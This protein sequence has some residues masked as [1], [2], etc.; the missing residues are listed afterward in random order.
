MPKLNQCYNY[1]EVELSV[2]EINLKEFCDRLKNHLLKTYEFADVCIKTD[3]EKSEQ[4]GFG[5]RN[6]LV[7]TGG[8]AF[9][10]NPKYRNVGFDI[11]EV[12]KNLNA[13]NLSVLGSCCAHPTQINGH[14]GEVVYITKNGNNNSLVGSKMGNTNTCSK[15]ETSITGGLGNFHLTEGLPNEPV[16]YLNVSSRMVGSI[17]QS[18]PQ[19]IRS[20]LASN[21]SYLNL[22]MGG[23]FQITKGTIKGHIQP[24]YVDCPE[25]YYDSFNDCANKPFL[26]FFETFATPSNP[27]ICLT[28]FWNITCETAS[29]KKIN[30]RSNSEHTHFFNKDNTICGHYHGDLL[31]KNGVN[32]ECYL[33][34]CDK[35]VKMRDSKIEHLSTRTRHEKLVMIVGAGAMGCLFGGILAE[36]GCHVHLVDPWKEH[37]DKINKFG[38]KLTG[39]GGDRT[40]KNLVAVT[41][42][43]ELS[44]TPDIVIVQCKSM[45]TKD[46]VKSI[47]NLVD[48]KTKFVS[49]QNG[50]GN[51]DEIAEILGSS[52]N[53]FGGQTLQGANIVKPGEV[54]IHT[55]LPSYIGSWKNKQNYLDAQIIANFF[56]RHGLPTYYDCDIEKRIWMKVIYNCVV[57]PYSA[58]TR[59]THRQVYSTPDA[60]ENANLIINEAVNVAF[61]EGIL[62]TDQEA[63]ECLQKVID[64]KQENKSSMCYDIEANRHSEINYING[65]IVKLAEKHDV[66]VP[67][68]KTMEFLIKSIEY[69]FKND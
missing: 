14:C 15:Y 61:K 2:K 1:D 62:I 46:A 50:L 20:F 54:N 52:D 43:D 6:I 31:D 58:L 65:R 18:L 22:G 49:F 51:E 9:C 4:Y 53:V 24:D 47:L 34:F 48:E 56:S 32:Y 44:L 26:H 68:N 38:L 41:N 12:K 64:S 28:N 55:N 45:Y 35:I 7:D 27:I 17:C 42:T 10:H 66:E 36:N 63:Q 30:F 69:N 37:V 3:Y 25:N 67:V 57:S 13:S 19:L 5:G 29:K 39:I 11:E 40:I 60:I 21:Y 16:I 23:I 8:E 59:L 33:T